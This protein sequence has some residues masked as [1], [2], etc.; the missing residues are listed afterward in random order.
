LQRA[1]EIEHVHNRGSPGPRRG[2]DDTAVG[3]RRRAA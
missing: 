2:C 3:G 1:C